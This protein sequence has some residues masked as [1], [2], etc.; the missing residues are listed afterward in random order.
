LAAVLCVAFGVVLMVQP[1]GYTVLSPGETADLLGTDG[2]RPLITISGHKTYRDQGQLRMLTVE[3]LPPSQKVSLPEAIGDWLQDDTSVYPSV[4]W[5]PPG[6]SDKS[7]QQQGAAQMTSALDLARAAAL[8]AAGIAVP[9]RVR[10]AGVV[11][12][13]PSDGKIKVGDIVT[14]VNGHDVS[15]PAEMLSAVQCEGDQTKCATQYKPG[16]VAN[17]VVERKGKRIPLSIKT[18]AA[19]AKPRIGVEISADPRFPFKIN[20]NIPDN[21]GGGSG[22]MMLALTIYDLLTSGHLTG[23]HVIAGT[24]TIGSGPGPGWGAV[25]PIGGID[26]KIR[27]A[28]R[29]GA[30]LFLAPAANCDEVRNATYNHN[31]MKIVKVSTLQDAITAITRWT[32]NPNDSALKGC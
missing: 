29:D 26:Q 13:G 9:M 2:T 19:S 28:Q 3:L 30:Q 4:V 27:G 23:G 5:Y 7:S 12:G 16:Y 22:G 32:K 24:G 18:V 11:A 14:S 21:I 6:S 25:G 10:I 31:T 15:S 17:V 1:T 8:Q 20:I